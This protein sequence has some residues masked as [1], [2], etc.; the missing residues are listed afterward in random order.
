MTESIVDAAV[1]VASGIIRSHPFVDG[2]TF[3]DGN[4]RTALMVVR[5][6][7]NLNEIEFAPPRE[8]TAD[9]MVE[10]ASGD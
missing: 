4:K 5:S 10:L 6:L 8:E 1:A 2:N 3:V 7:L 9:A